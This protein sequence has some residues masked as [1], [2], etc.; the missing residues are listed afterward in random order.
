MA[1]E[2]RAGAGRRFAAAMQRLA[3]LVLEVLFPGRCLVCGVRL[4]FEP[5]GA[6]P[7]CSACLARLEPIAGRR[8]RV[9]SAPLLSEQETCLRC[10]ETGYAF[11]AHYAVFE[12]RGAVKDLIYQYKFLNRRRIAP[13]FARLLHR[14]L[15]SRFPGLPVVPVP[16]RRRL[17]PAG[18]GHHLERIARL[19]ERRHGVR[20]LRVLRR[21]GRRPQKALNLEERRRNIR[22]AV[23][24]TGGARLPYSQVALLDDVFTT[25]ATADECARVLLQA[26]IREVGVLTLAMD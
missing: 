6:G 21:K 10:R 17:G 16:S 18:G 15:Q 19:L 7:V 8:C 22:G 25:G 2:G 23:S 24:F 5:P 9:C 3:A 13:L 20:V 1:P 14:E 4:L 12:Y 11:R 26:G